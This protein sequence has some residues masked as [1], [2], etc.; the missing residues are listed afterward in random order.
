[1]MK[2]L[3]LVKYDLEVYEDSYD[4]DPTLSFINMQSPIAS[5]SI[6]DRFEHRADG[7]WMNPPGDN[8]CLRISDISHIVYE[9]GERSFVGNKVMICVKVEDI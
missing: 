9:I 7:D 2:E 4:N 1:M 3:M 5:M 8:Q 6:G